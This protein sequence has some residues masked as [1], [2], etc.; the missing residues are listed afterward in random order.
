MLGGVLIWGEG[1]HMLGGGPYI[2][3]IG[4]GTYMGGSHLW[5]AG[6]ALIWG[7]PIRRLL[8]GHS[9]YVFGGGGCTLGSVPP[10]EGGWGAQC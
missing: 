6:G 10:K 8:K 3:R 4:G 5:G 1:A 7:G 9:L 2:G